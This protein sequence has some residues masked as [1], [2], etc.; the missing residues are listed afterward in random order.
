MKVTK[1]EEQKKDATRVSIYIDDKFDF[2]MSQD[3]LIK[4]GLYVGMELTEIQLIQLK[5][6]VEF[7]KALLR[8]INYISYQQR[9]E[10]EVH[11]KL[12]KLEYNEAMCENVIQKLKD[13]KY[14]NDAYYTKEYIEYK[15]Q[16]NGPNKIIQKLRGKGITKDMIEDYLENYDDDFFYEKAYVLAQKKNEGF[17]C[18]VTRDK[19]YTRMSQ[20]LVSRGYHYGIVKDVVKEM[21]KDF[22]DQPKAIQSESQDFNEDEDYSNNQYENDYAELLRLAKKKYKTYDDKFDVYKKREKLIRYLMGKR[23]SYEMIKTMIQELSY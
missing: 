21:L 17:A 13:Y 3:L 15:V 23:Y 22:K 4:H 9:T 6:D 18:S 10:K 12:L 14:I 11:D 1:L 5:N 19:R 20:Y 8:A 2:G 7:N 16:S